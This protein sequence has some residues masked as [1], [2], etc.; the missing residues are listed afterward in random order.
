MGITI[1]FI[2][3]EIGAHER[4]LAKVMLLNSCFLE[5]IKFEKR[6]RNAMKMTQI[7]KRLYFPKRLN[8]SPLASLSYLGLILPCSPQ[9][10]SL[11]YTEVLETNISFMLEH[12]QTWTW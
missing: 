5:E 3:I 12:S 6:D 9:S 4:G 8:P 1:P 2:E 7:N 10:N 11:S